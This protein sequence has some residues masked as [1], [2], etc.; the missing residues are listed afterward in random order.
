MSSRRILAPTLLV[1][2]G[3]YVSGSRIAAQSATPAAGLP[4][5]VTGVADLG[6]MFGGAMVIEKFATQANGIVAIGTISG[7]VTG[8]G[9]FRNLVFQAALP[10]DINASRAR[11]ST[12]PALAAQTSCDVL[13]VELASASVNVLGSTIGLNPISFDIASAVQANGSPSGVATP[14]SSTASSQ[15]GGATTSPSPGTVTGSP[16]SNATQ[17]GVGSPSI[18][19]AT[20]PAVTTPPG[21]TPGAPAPGVAT[22]GATT[23]VPQTKPTAAAQTALGSLLCSVNRFRDVSNPTQVTQQLNGILAALAGTQ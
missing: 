18:P 11:L 15:P 21:A 16:S 9:T 10:L 14:P 6:G 8:N 2:I 17:A 7:A 23:P 5:P 22:P 20:T 13:H 3:I 12:D 4:V 1:V 19:D